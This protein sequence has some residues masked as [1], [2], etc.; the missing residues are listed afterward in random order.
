MIVYLDL[1]VRNDM[2]LR[3]VYPD[4]IS[5]IQIITYFKT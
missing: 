2:F 3:C 5:K 1:F 4:Y